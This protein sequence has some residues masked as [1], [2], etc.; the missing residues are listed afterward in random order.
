MMLIVFLLPR[1]VYLRMQQQTVMADDKLPH[2]PRRRTGANRQSVEL[3]DIFAINSILDEKKKLHELPRYVVEN[4]DRTRLYDGD[5]KFLL[6]KLNKV[7]NT[8]RVIDSLSY[9]LT[10]EQDFRIRE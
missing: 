10:G 7:D 8:V 5:M 1:F 6:Y 2:F 9:R 3:D 4:P